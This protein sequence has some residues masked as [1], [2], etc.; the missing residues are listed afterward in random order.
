MTKI[1]EPLPWDSDDTKSFIPVSYKGNVIGFCKPD[2]AP[3]ITAILNDSTKYRK[4]FELACADLSAKAGGMPS[5]IDYQQQYLVRVERP[6][7]GIRVIARLLQE[8][9]EDLN[10]NDEAFAKFCDTFRLSRVELKNIYNG[11]EID[12]NQLTPLSRILG[13]TID[14]L[15]ILWKGR[16]D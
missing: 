9:Q 13:I 1:N 16:D 10:F 12:S 3:K 4:A 5:A 6:T 7:K 11:E 14:E 2:V 15:I 8:R